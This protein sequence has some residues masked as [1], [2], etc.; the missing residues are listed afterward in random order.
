METEYTADKLI[1]LYIQDT[2]ETI[3]PNSQKLPFFSTEF[4]FNTFFHISNPQLLLPKQQ[5][6]IKN[7][8]EIFK[9]LLVSLCVSQNQEVV[10]LITIKT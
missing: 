7:K 1:A 4:R 2:K 6:L 8:S 10:S 3:P 5:Q 9:I